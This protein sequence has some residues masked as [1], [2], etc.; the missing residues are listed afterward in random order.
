M[1]HYA[2][3]AQ[4]FEADAADFGTGASL[5]LAFPADAEAFQINVEG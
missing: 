4:R 5:R 1:M 2:W 3:P